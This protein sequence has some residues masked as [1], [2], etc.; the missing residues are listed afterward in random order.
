M[1][2]NFKK[3]AFTTL[4]LCLC[5]TSIASTGQFFSVSNT[6]YVLHVN[7]TI[8]NHTYNDASIRLTSPGY[9]TYC[10]SSGKYIGGTES[11]R[12][13]VSDTSTANFQILGPTGTVDAVICLNG[14]LP[15]VCQQ[16]RFSVAAYAFITNFANSF[17][18]QVGN[19]SI[20]PVN[21]DRSLGTCSSFNDAS[22]YGPI[23]MAFNS[24]GTWAYI[25]NFQTNASVGS[26]SICSVNQTTGMLD[27]P[28]TAFPLRSGSRATA[29][30]LNRANTLA[31]IAD[32]GGS[33]VVI[34][35]IINNGAS[36]GTCTYQS[37]NF[38]KPQTVQLDPRENYIYLGN[39]TPDNDMSICPINSDG[40]LGTCVRS[41]GD[42]TFDVPSGVR[43][44]KLGTV[45]YS[46][47]QNTSTISICNANLLTGL[48]SNCVAASDPTFNFTASGSTLIFTSDP[49]PY[50]FAPN[51]TT[52][53]VSVCS[54]ESDNLL[55][56]CIAYASSTFDQPGSVNIR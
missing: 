25:T 34:C 9:I 44:T 29:I 38:V 19:V 43:F 12:F 30:S 55:A 18:T 51:T 2:W 11:C 6:N 49:Y 26:I 46:S 16:V 5:Q 32:S 13:S 54:I 45:S 15:S 27:S 1:I 35:P 56:P 52:D 31:Y 37:G 23:G 4:L 40:S 48:L 42:N 22:F 20:C 33:T 50:L 21:A 10:P 8:Q 24:A 41:T 36:F 17:G 53:T 39:F 28:C 47:N 7:T 14:G 3:I